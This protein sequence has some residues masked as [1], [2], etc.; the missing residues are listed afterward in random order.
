MMGVF[1]NLVIYD[2]HKPQNSMDTNRARA[3]GGWAW[4]DDKMKLYVSRLR[5]GVKWHDGRHSHR[6]GRDTRGT[7]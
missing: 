4:S 6:Q 1:N 2:Q 5:E 3:G 7:C